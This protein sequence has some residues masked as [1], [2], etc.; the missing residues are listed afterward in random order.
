MTCSISFQ[1]LV[2]KLIN[3]NKIEYQTLKFIN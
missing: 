2:E 1:E 3:E